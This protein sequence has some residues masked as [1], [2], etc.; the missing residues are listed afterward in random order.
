MG[1]VG[2]FCSLPVISPQSS[3]YLARAL[4][5]HTLHFLAVV[6]RR[7]VDLGP[8]HQ[9]AAS[10]FQRLKFASNFFSVYPILTDCPAH[11]GLKPNNVG[12]SHSDKWCETDRD[13]E[14]LG[15]KQRAQASTCFPDARGWLFTGMSL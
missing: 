14:R 9:R 5:K 13:A 7:L 12:K 8:V 3:W 11:A 4:P 2:P 1:K 6:T 10:G 15:G